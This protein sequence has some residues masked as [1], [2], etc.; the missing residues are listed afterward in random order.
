MKTP[1]PN[2][3]SEK[4]HL[5]KIENSDLEHVFRGLSNPDIIKYYG[6]WYDS[7]R[8]TKAQMKWYDQLEKSGT[9]QWWA[10]CSKREKEFLGAVGLS[11]LSTKNKKAE[12][13]FWLY[14]EYWGKGLMSEAVSLVCRHGFRNM[15]LHR[16]EAFVEPPNVHCKK[17]I[18]KLNFNYEGR[19]VE[20]EV[21]N[22]KFIDLEIYANLENNN[23]IKDI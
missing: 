17:L 16:I 20:C 14:P 11:S 1:V 15:G 8:A 2:L 13:G 22:G 9:G 5:R 10:V 21:K 3:E 4:V 7:L 6:V 23:L 19:M 12:I 18:N